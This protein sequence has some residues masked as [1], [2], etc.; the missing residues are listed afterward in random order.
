MMKFWSFVFLAALT[1]CAGA[2]DVV[3][4]SQSEYEAELRKEYPFIEHKKGD[5][6]S[7]AIDRG[8]TIIS[9]KIIRI[10]PK[11][12]LIESDGFE[13]LYTFDRLGD[14]GGRFFKQDK[15]D[16]W[17]S[18]RA[19]EILKSKTQKA[20]A[21]TQQRLRQEQKA[22]AEKAKKARELA[23]AR[24]NKI[25][26]KFPYGVQVIQVFDHS[27]LARDISCGDIVY[28]VGMSTKDLITDQ[29]IT[30]TIDE[31]ECKTFVAWR[32]GTHRYASVDGGTNT[33][34]K[35]TVNKAEAEN[36]LEQ[37]TVQ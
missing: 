15:Y 6:V 18:K 2:A 24:I 14:E 21:Q 23:E 36:Y 26:K 13:I 20:E 27:I 5:I 29:E 7:F 34:A 3:V 37:K 31:R 35:F 11:G 17:I 28:I 19:A 30:N 22:E 8:K 4:K 33:V 9:G 10:D 32:I 12:V 1:V 16:L 25:K